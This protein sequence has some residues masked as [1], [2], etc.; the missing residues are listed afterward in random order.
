M[1]KVNSSS[2]ICSAYAESRRQHMGEIL[3][4]AF[5]LPGEKPFWMFVV[6]VCKMNDPACK[7]NEGYLKLALQRSRDTLGQWFVTWKM[8]VNVGKCAVVK[9]G[10]PNEQLHADYTLHGNVLKISQAEKRSRCYHEQHARLQVTYPSSCKQSHEGIQMD[11]SKYGEQ[12]YRHSPESLEITCE[13]DFGVRQCRLVTPS[14]WPN[15]PN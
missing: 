5:F 2:Y 9:F 3:R 1:Y 7:A 15:K 10:R 12:G 13:T 4:Y 14:S 8:P 11:C 6:M